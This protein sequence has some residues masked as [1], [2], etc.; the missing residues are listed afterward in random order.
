MADQS[1]SAR[2]QGLFETALQGYER[3]TGIK[4]AEHPLAVEIQNC[5]TVDEVTSLLQCQAQ[6]FKEND[7]IIKSIKTIVSVLSSVSS[8]ISLADAFGVVRQ[9][10]S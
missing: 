3:K 8:A 10:C 9:N 2:F 5:D 1:E 6:A 4:W 7:K